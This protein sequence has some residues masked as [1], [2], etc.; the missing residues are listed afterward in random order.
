MFAGYHN[1]A[2]VCVAPGSV[3]LA[4]CDKACSHTKGTSRGTPWQ[5][6]YRRG[7]PPKAAIAYR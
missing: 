1:Y 3:T 6:V 5:A 2:A 7:L 4:S